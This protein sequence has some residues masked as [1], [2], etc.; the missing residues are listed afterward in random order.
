MP[1][2][3]AFRFAREFNNDPLCELALGAAPEEFPSTE[4]IAVAVRLLTNQHALVDSMK[5][6]L[7]NDFQGRGPES[8]MWW[9]GNVDAVNQVL[10]A[11]LGTPSQLEGQDDLLDVMVPTTIQVRK[12]VLGYDKAVAQVYFYAAFE[13]EHGIGILTDGDVVLGIGY[14][15]DVT[16]FHPES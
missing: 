9:R 7:W 5:E 11:E 1:A 12:R 2:F 15:A 6:S 4:Q 13:E 10:M 14:A 3:L 16:P 8:G